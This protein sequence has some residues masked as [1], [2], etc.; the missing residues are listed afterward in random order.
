MEMLKALRASGPVE[1]PA[2]A[3]DK[4]VTRQTIFMRS[5]GPLGASPEV[6]SPPSGP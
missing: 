1:A 6:K 2:G 4:I 5:S 3:A